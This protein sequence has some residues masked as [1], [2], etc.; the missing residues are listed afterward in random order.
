MTDF[1]Y[2]RINQVH[3]KIK[4]KFR[5]D[6]ISD[7]IKSIFGALPNPLA[8]IRW[9]LPVLLGTRKRLLEDRATGGHD[10]DEQDD[11]LHPPKKKRFLS[12]SRFVF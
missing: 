10:S 7:Q 5:S 12:T 4:C 2:N 8:P 1:L 3:I 11:D 9:V 6:K